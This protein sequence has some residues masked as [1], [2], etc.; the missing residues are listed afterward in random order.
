L[1]DKSLE[2]DDDYEE[3]V[4]E[5]MKDSIK[6]FPVALTEDYGDMEMKERDPAPATIDSETKEGTAT[7]EDMAV[8]EAG[9]TDAIGQGNLMIDKNNSEVVSSLSRPICNNFLT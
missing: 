3:D 7:S 6:D 1:V 8:K 2:E 9:S 5:L 4:I